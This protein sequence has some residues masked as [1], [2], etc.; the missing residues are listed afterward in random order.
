MHY[1]QQ[2]EGT[3]QQIFPLLCPNREKDWLDGWS[4]DM[5]YSK[6]GFAE[7]NCVFSTSIHGRETTFWMVS[8]YEPDQGIIEFVRLTPKEMVVKISI[9]VHQEN[10]G[11]TP[12]EVTYIYTALAEEQEK[13]LKQQLAEDFRKS[14]EW[15]EK[16]MNYYLRTGEML[17]R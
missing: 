13:Y 15:W 11:I 7:A 12:V 2:I 4:Y 3:L 16:A 8:R 9:R 10:K 5:I 14:M 6:S 1:I 17:G